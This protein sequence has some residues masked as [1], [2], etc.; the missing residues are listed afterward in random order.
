YVDNLEFKLSTAVQPPVLEVPH[1]FVPAFD[2][3]F[4]VMMENTTY[5]DVIGDR[6]N[7][8]FINFLADKGMLLTH[9][10]GTYHPSDEN[11]LAIA[12]GAAFVKGGVYFPNITVGAGTIADHLG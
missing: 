9:S 6:K 11:Y 12:G 1:S 4:L 8:P 5:G 3:V 10:S 7:A 2:H